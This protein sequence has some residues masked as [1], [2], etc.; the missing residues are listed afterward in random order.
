MGFIKSSKNESKKASNDIKHVTE[1]PIS[2]ITDNIAEP[3]QQA[4]TPVERAFTAPPAQ[5]YKPVQQNIVAPKQAKVIA[6]LQMQQIPHQ[7]KLIQ[8]AKLLHLH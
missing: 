4:F 8:Q 6:P 1:T 3:I 2:H 5:I 7:L